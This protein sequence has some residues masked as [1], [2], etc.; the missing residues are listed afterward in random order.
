ME[1]D[2]VEMLYCSFNQDLKRFAVGVSTGFAIFDTENFSL[3]YS[4]RNVWI[5]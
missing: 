5:Y 3:L 2:K 1:K 4:Y